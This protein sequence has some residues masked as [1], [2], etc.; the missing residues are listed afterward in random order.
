MLSGYAIKII[1]MFASLDQI[2]QI[3]LSVPFYMALSVNTE[4]EIFFALS[5]KLM[6]IFQKR[7]SNIKFEHLV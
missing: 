1:N 2:K 3:V 4:Y 5:K 7:T 6:M